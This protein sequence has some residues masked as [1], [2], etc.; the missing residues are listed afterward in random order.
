MRPAAAAAAAAAARSVRVGVALE[1]M[2][3]AAAEVDDVW[4]A[5]LRALCAVEGEHKWAEHVNMMASVAQLHKDW[6]EELVG[7][8]RPSIEDSAP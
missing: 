5:G 3:A 6:V 8:C 2:A 4:Q 7:K 1:A